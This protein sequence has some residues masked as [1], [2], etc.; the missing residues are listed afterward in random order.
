MEEQTNIS[1]D[2]FELILKNS[3]ALNHKYNIINDDNLSSK[4]YKEDILKCFKLDVFI[5]FRLLLICD[6][7]HDF[8]GVRKKDPDLTDKNKTIWKHVKELQRYCTINLINDT[9]YLAKKLNIDST[10]IKQIAENN[11][12]YLLKYI[13]SISYL[14]NTSLD[15][16]ETTDLNVFTYCRILHLQ[17]NPKTQHDGFIKQMNNKK[18]NTSNYITTDDDAKKISNN[19]LLYFFKLKSVPTK[20]LLD[21]E[22]TNTVQDSSMIFILKQ[23]IKITQQ[24]SNGDNVEVLPFYGDKV[25]LNIDAVGSSQELLPYFNELAKIIIDKKCNRAEIV[26]EKISKIV[27]N[28]DSLILTTNISNNYDTAQDSIL[29]TYMRQAVDTNIVNKNNIQVNLTFCGIDIINY[30]ISDFENPVMSITKYFRMSIT[31]TLI[32]EK[33]ASES[34]SRILNEVGQNN[35]QK[36][37]TN[38]IS[39]STS[40][41]KVEYMFDTTY[42]TLSDFSQIIQFCDDYYNGKDKLIN[43]SFLTFDHICFNVANIL[44]PN[45]IGQIYDKQIFN[46]LSVYIDINYYEFIINNKAKYLEF[47]SEIKDNSVSAAS[48]MINL[49]KNPKNPQTRTSIKKSK[50]RIPKPNNNTNF[51]KNT[52][53]KAIKQD[54]IKSKTKNIAKSLG[55]RL[56]VNKKQKSDKILKKQIKLLTRFANKQ[57]VKLNKYTYKNCFVLQNAISLGIPLK[58]LKNNQ[59]IKKTTK[60]LEKQI[61]I[62]TKFAKK[63]KI[64]FDKNTYNKAIK[65]YN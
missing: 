65:K 24:K 9:S 13:N 40:V 16:L 44:C 19:L 17:I 20:Y 33:I 38:T 8:I 59:V 37:I 54:L 26:N 28:K 12:F 55:I 58:I 1:F 49:K 62:L 45:I 42:K 27:S 36:H 46:G 7:C 4:E 18:Q 14:I 2:I 48:I 22:W 11:E 23:Y 51:G 60:L 53:K 57:N 41:S 52:Y 32:E 6:V 10:K 29:H 35:I 34:K 30:S 64:K 50:S 31:P 39:T 56:S 3:I 61:K 5:S 25:S 21:C 47:L 15:I 43:K 63:H